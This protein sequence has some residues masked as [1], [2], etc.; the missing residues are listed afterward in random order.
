[1]LSV[2]WRASAIRAFVFG[3]C[4]IAGLI[5]VSLKIRL[6]IKRLIDFNFISVNIIFTG[7]IDFAINLS[8]FFSGFLRIGI[9][10][11]N[12]IL[13]MI[14]DGRIRTIDFYY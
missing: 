14:F 5:G 4:S 2:G 6:S 13:L 8:S 9:I 11:L 12:G 10:Y 1:L 3:I 7:S